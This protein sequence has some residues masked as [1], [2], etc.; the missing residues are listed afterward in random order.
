MTKAEEKEIREHYADLFIK[1][2]LDDMYY[3]SAINFIKIVLERLEIHS[4]TSKS[5]V[6][7]D[8]SLKKQ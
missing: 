1:Q 2:N 7:K 3:K 6:I 5:R 8:N 4:K